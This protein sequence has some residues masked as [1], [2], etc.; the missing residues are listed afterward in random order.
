MGPDGK[1]P[2]KSVLV[3]DDHP[4]VRRLIRTAF[5]KRPDFVVCGEAGDGQEAIEKAETLRPDLVVLDLSMPGMN[6]LAVARH[7]KQSSPSTTV[8]VFS[9][10]LDV[11]AEGGRDFAGIAAVVSK[12]QP[13]SVLID[14]A[15]H[16]L[17]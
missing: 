17:N 1:A 4:T 5:E 3:A 16:L 2:P 12:S 8:I 10:Y 13:L 14:E 7:L 15:R 9:D 11:L 6:G